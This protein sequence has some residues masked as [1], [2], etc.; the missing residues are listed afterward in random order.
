[1]VPGRW[2]IFKMKQ[3]RRAITRRKDEIAIYP[4]DWVV[5]G[6]DTYR[7]WCRIPY[8]GHPKGCDMWYSKRKNCDTSFRKCHTFDEVFDRA[9]PAWVVWE[10]FD[11]G[12]HAEKIGRAHV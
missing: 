1:M 2:D 5:V 8:E 6:L 4:E 3:R 9:G 7:S 10:A 11:L 12:A